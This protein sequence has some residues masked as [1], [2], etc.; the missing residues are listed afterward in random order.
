MTELPLPAEELRARID[1]LPRVRLAALPT[2]LH[3]C[4]RLS[5]VLGVRLFMKRDDLTGLAFGGNKTRQFEF[6][7]AEAQRQ[8]ATVIIAGAA[9]QSN[10]CRQACAAAAQLGMKIDLT[11]IRGVKGDLMQGNF[12]LFHLLGAK[13]R[14]VDVENWDQMQAL[15]EERAAE[16]AAR[17]ERPFIINVKGATCPLGAVGYVDAFLEL[18]TQLEQAGVVPTTIFLAA[19]NVTPCGLALGAKLRGSP[20]RVQGFS[21]IHWRQPRT[22]DIARISRQTA[23]LLGLDVWLSPEEVL[24]DENYVGE[25]YGIPTPQT[26]EVIRLVAQTEGILLDPVYT[27]KAFAAMKDYID[28][29]RV[30]AGATV[31]FLHTGGQPALFAYADEV[32]GSGAP[33][34]P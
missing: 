18:E 14:V 9:T 31:V 3:E 32:S 6:I 28:T 5:E 12:L 22:D 13:T 2:P 25:G 10:F 1:A 21:P 4:P 27:G 16:Y 8:G 29:G 33:F 24:N 11:L 17:G 7:F 19:A 23:A 15:F 20:I 34:P 26:V 30:P